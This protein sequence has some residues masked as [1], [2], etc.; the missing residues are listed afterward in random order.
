MSLGRKI[1]NIAGVQPS[2][3]KRLGRLGRGTEIARAD[4]RPAHQNLPV[5][6]DSDFDPGNRSSD[7]AGPDM[8]RVV[9]ADD[10]RG[11]RQPVALHDGVAEAAPECLQIGRQRRAS[12]NH[13]TEFPAEQSVHLA[14]TPPEQGPWLVRSRFS[15]GSRGKTMHEEFP[16]KV[17]LFRYGHENRGTP[18]PEL[19]AH[20]LRGRRGDEDHRSGNERWHKC[21]QRL[22]EQ[23]AHRKQVE[24][25]DRS[26]RTNPLQIRLEL[27]FDRAQIRRQI[28]VRDDDTLGFGRRP[29]RE[30]D[31][32]DVVGHERTSFERRF[33]GH[34]FDFRNRPDRRP[35]ADAFQ[36][37]DSI[38][39][40]NNPRIDLL[41]DPLEQNG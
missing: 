31:F 14:E 32:S 36:S 4:I 7:R 41:P 5:G 25:A 15:A 2:F 37:R 38:T 26:E 40:Q 30:D 8:K 11:F 27:L 29:R 39:A 10:R 1:A 23:V 9:E 12:G 33:T 6:G 35:L 20:F 21:G 13:T 18:A 24:D 22:A 28:P 3:A 19:A 17:K 34:I 16:Q